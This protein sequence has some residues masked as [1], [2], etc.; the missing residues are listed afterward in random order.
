MARFVTWISFEMPTLETEPHLS[1]AV[2]H[3]PG[4]VSAAEGE[5]AQST[6]PEAIGRFRGSLKK[7][8]KSVLGTGLE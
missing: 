5:V 4:F 8:Y 6:S 7:Y 2:E 3:S 1:D